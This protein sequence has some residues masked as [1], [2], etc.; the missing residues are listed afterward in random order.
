MMSTVQSKYQSWN[1]FCHLHKSSINHTKSSDSINQLF[2]SQILITASTHCEWNEWNRSFS[3]TNINWLVHHIR[4]I[5]TIL[6][7]RHVPA[8]EKYFFVDLTLVKC[9]HIFPRLWLRS[10]KTK[11]WSNKNKLLKTFRTTITSGSVKP[12]M[13]TFR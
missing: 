4:L 8:H 5:R 13:W 12:F 6:Y 11:C 3:L 10:R 2:L 7:Q 1:R 9:S